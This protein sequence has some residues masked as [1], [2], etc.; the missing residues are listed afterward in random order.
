MGARCALPMSM[1][2]SHRGKRS[3]RSFT[4]SPKQT[5]SR[6]T[7]G[8]ICR[9][10][11]MSMSLFAAASVSP[12]MVMNWTLPGVGAWIEGPSARRTRWHPHPGMGPPR[13][14]CQGLRAPSSDGSRPS[15]SGDR[16]APPERQLHALRSP[17]SEGLPNRR[18][19]SGGR[20]DGLRSEGGACL[21]PAD[22]R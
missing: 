16:R 13:S 10:W 18:T 8:L 7:L 17:S 19:S 1:N 6:A 14:R 2:L 20:L 4:R 12:V 11:I 3:R 9:S 5:S 22:H 21:R 15:Q